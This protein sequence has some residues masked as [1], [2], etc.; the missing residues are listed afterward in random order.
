MPRTHRRDPQ[1]ATAGDL[2]AALRGLVGAGSTHLPAAVAMR[3]RDVAPPTD[4]DL[5]EAER[6]LA[7]RPARPASRPGGG[8]QPRPGRQ[9]QEAGDAASGMD[10]ASPVRS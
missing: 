1:A 3:A 9:A 4:A 8:G 2:D 10:G 7:L 6:T 5:A